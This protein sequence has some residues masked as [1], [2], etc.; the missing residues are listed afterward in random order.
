[1]KKLTGIVLAAA[2]VLSA[3]T[4]VSAQTVADLQAQIDALLAQLSAVATT[5]TTTT[6]TGYSFVSDLTIGSTGPAVVELQTAL[7]LQ[8]TLVMPAGVSRGYFGPLTQAALGMYQASVGISP[9]S[10]YFG[11]ITRAHFNSLVA[12][13]VPGTTPGTTP[14]T[15]SSNDLDGGEA[16]LEDFDISDGT[17]D[18]IEE[19]SVGEVAVIEFDVEDGDVRVERLD[20]SFVF[21]GTSGEDN[22]WDAF[23]T[24]TLMADGKEIASEDVSDEDDWLDEDSNDEKDDPYT[25]R[26][27]NL[28]YVVREGDKAEITV[29]IETQNGI[30]DSDVYV[31]NDWTVFVDTYDIRALDAAGIDQYTG[32]DTETV[33]FSID[34]EGADDELDIRASSN[35]PESTTLVVE[36]D[37]TSEDFTVFVFE[38]EADEDGSDIEIDT[39]GGIRV[40]T[41]GANYDKVVNDAMLMIDGMEFNDF[42]VVYYTSS[43]FATET[44]SNGTVASAFAELEFDIDGDFTLDAGDTVDVEV[45]LEFKSANGVNGVTAVSQVNTVDL[46]AAAAN[47]TTYTVG[48]NATLYSITSDADATEAEIHTALAAAINASIAQPV[49]ATASATAL[50]LTADVAGTPFSA[51]ISANLTNTVTTA[52]RAANAGSGNYSAG[53]TVQ[54]SVNGSDIMGDGADNVTGD[55]SATGDV[56]TLLVEGI[57]ANT[58]STS[59]SVEVIEGDDNDYAEFEINLDVMAFEEDAFISENLATSFNFSIVNANTGVVVYNSTTGPSAAVVASISSSA[60]QQGTYYRIDEGNT[61]DFALTVSYTPGATSGSYRLQLDSI[62]FNDTAAAP[63]AE[64]LTIPAQDYRTGNA[65]V[66]N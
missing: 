52:N 58:T 14:G 21:D 63:D 42:E 10:G 4:S 25:F 48:I 40:T 37:K 38:M 36:D 61:E 11:P 55:G 7:E 22:P 64:Y 54:V 50:T 66:T 57:D 28:D 12:P 29:E 62:E 6:A 43:T 19:G 24:I 51:S 44:G 32:D 60:D 33:S 1:M 31:A 8:G 2:F 49:T 9:A 17:D 65:N 41:T 30:D 3:T 45:V 5:G 56:H 16:S 18:D 23:D 15:G 20:L 26:F 27:S 35:D 53:A 39:I 59:K 46:A 47:A 34:E 13:T